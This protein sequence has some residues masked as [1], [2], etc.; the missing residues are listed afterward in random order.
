MVKSAIHKLRGEEEGKK[1][2]TKLTWSNREIYFH[3]KSQWKNLIKKINLKKSIWKNNLKKINLKKSIW[4]NNLKKIN[5]KKTIWKNNLKKINLKK[6]IWKNQFEKI[7]LKKSIWKKS[8]WK[9]LIKKIN[10]KKSI[11]KNRFKSKCVFEFKSIKSIK[12]SLP[13]H[14]GAPSSV[15]TGGGGR[16]RLFSTGGTLTSCFKLSDSKKTGGGSVD[17]FRVSKMS[18]GGGG[19]LARKPLP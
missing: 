13:T 17:V 11:W 14:S 6:S 18:Y 12:I 9:N 8:I 3:K 5:L 10:L 19:A 1:I 16:A 2:Q 15:F 7:N 4:K